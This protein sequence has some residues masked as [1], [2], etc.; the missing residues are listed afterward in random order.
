[1]SEYTHNDDVADLLYAKDQ[2][3][4]ELQKKLEY[5]RSM[6]NQLEKDYARGL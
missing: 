5:V 2:E 3:I 4:A 6:L 1:V